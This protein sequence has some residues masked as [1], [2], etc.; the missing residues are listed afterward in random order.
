D[1][2]FALTTTLQNH[3]SKKRK[4]NLSYEII[5][6]DGTVVQSG[7]KKLSLG[8]NEAQKVNFEAVLADVKPW[9]AETANLYTVVVQISDKKAVL[10]SLPNRVGFRT[11]EVEN[12]LLKVNGQIITLKG[13]NTQEHNPETGHV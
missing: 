6:A 8:A 13:V 2:V 9:T 3:E 4:L 11:V 1:G 5:D 12:G 7:S 10:E